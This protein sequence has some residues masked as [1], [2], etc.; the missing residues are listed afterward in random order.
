MIDPQQTAREH[1][2]P[3]EHLYWAGMSD[4]ARLIS[5]RDGFLI[6]FSLL[7]CGFVAFWTVSAVTSGAPPFF[8]VVGSLF[9]L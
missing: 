4:P 5:G 9:T 3:D 2:R 1:L 7:W 6:P 8:L